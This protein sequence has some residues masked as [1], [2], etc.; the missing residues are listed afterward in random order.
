MAYATVS[1]VQQQNVVRTIS[2][3]SRPNASQVIDWLEQTAA[4][5]DGLLRE[6]GYSLP[7]PTTATQV[8]KLLEH[9]NAL[10]AAALVER[11]APTSDRRKEAQELW[12]GAQK[13][14]RDDLLN[15]DAPRDEATR[16]IRAPAYAT[17]MFTR[18]QEL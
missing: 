17:P 8:L 7:V 3:T 13:M 18:D 12:E 6:S 5:L 11:G 1:D 10:G 14:L 2:A 9:Y 16:T 15:L 4:V